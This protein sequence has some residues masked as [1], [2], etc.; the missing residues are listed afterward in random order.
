M[1]KETFVFLL[2]AF[3]SFCT[4]LGIALGKIAEEEKATQK[5]DS[6]VSPTPPEAR[7]EQVTAVEEPKE[8]EEE[9][10][11]TA[12]RKELS[13]QDF[14]TEMTNVTKRGKGDIVQKVLADFGVKKL[15]E[16][17]KEDYD[18]VLTRVL[19]FAGELEVVDA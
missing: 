14:R 3:S 7:E 1:N 2:E 11:E 18:D 15:S 17:K 10:P 4:N 19:Y 9:K 16:V 6:V 8:P 13:F 5:A 12:E